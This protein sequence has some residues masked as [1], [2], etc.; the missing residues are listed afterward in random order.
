MGMCAEIICIGPYS[1]SVSE[2]MEYGSEY[3]ASTINGA[4]I[5]RTLFGI[6]EG[7]ALSRDFSLFMGINDVWDFNQHKIDCRKIDV[8]GLREFACRYS[9]YDEDVDALLLFMENGFEF[10]FCPVG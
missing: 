6:T 7:S 5:S 8:E 2:C 9:H 3:Y 1:E 10:H 4:I